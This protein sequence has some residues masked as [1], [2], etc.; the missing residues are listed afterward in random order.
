MD[1]TFEP[2]AI[3]SDIPERPNTSAYTRLQAAAD[4]TATSLRHE[5]FTPTSMALFILPLLDGSRSRAELVGRV[6]EA[7]ASGKVTI[8]GSELAPEERAGAFVDAA[9]EELRGGGVLRG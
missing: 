4:G 7:L 2:P 1:V 9:L 6:E 5:S 8:E 3:A